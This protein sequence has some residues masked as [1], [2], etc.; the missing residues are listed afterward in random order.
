[1]TLILLPYYAAGGTIVP[2]RCS[3]ETRVDP[4]RPVWG[5]RMIDQGG[6][7]HHPTCDRFQRAWTEPPRVGRRNDKGAISGRSIANNKDMLLRDREQYAGFAETPDS[8]FT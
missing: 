3:P 8:P 2:V 1:M 5:L 6:G 7:K 4:C